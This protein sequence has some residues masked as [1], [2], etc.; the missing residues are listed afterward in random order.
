MPRPR[1]ATTNARSTP[2]K[3]SGD[4]G[5]RSAL[6]AIQ[7]LVV[8]AL[9]LVEAVSAALEAVARRAAHS[10]AADLPVAAAAR[11]LAA[12]DGRQ[13]GLVAIVIALGRGKCDKPGAT[14]A[15]HR[16]TLKFV[17]V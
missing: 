12:R 16:A 3:R 13:I 14:D 7:P 17:H 6:V 15:E 8:E 9:P 10:A 11:V 2:P 1:R 5:K 4:G